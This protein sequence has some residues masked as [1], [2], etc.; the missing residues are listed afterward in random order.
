[1]KK[2]ILKSIVGVSLITTSIT[3][4]ST[5]NKVI[6]EHKN[7]GLCYTELCMNTPELESEVEKRSLEGNLP[8]E[9]GL[10]LIKRWTQNAT[11]A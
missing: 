4:A 9:M 7:T 8:F 10:E 6:K 3:Y 11:T 1:M 5:T 2:N